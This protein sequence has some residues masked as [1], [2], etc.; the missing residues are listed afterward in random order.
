M[1]L[2]FRRFTVPVFI[3]LFT[4]VFRVGPARAQLTES[5][6]KVI[7][8]LDQNRVRSQIQYLSEGVVKT[9]SGQGAGTAVVGS[10]EEAELGQVVAAEMKKIGL[11]VRTEGY[12][13]RHYTSG[14]VTLT[15][16]GKPI[17]AI[18]LHAAGGTWG[19]RDGVPYAYG[20]EEHGHRLRA[21][22]V[23]AG[24]GYLPDY[25]RVGSVRGKIVLVRRGEIWP[26]YQIL[27][28]AHQG[29]VGLLMYDFPTAP[30][31]AIRQDS[32]W[33]HEQLPTASIAKDDAKR[34]QAQLKA[35]PVEI[36]LENRIDSADG[37]SQN[38]IGTIT[39][40]ELPDE[41]LLVAAHYD[42]WWQSANDNCAGAAT[43]LE[44]ARALKSSHPRRGI[45]FL[46][47]S[48]EE[49]GIEATEFDWLAGSHAFVT[50][51]PEIE[52]RLVY[53]FN[54]DMSGWTAK[55]AT[56]YT[57]PELAS[58]QPKVIADLDLASR[59]K[60]HLGQDPDQDAWNFGTVGGGSVS[61]L[62][63]GDFGG[64][65]GNDPD[66]NP[67]SQYYHT[68]L[69]VYRPQDFD[70]LQSH[71]RLGAL[72]LL[73]M[74]QAINAPVDFE[75]VADWI[76]K[77]WEGEQVLATG[78]SYSDAQE[79]LNQF[80]SEAARVGAARAKFASTAQATPANLWLMRVRK[81]LLPWVSSFSSTGVR[82]TPNAAVLAAVH[83]AR[84][85]AEKNDN[86]ST[87]TALEQVDAAMAGWETPSVKAAGVVSPEV[88][89]EERIYWYTSGDWSAA[90]EQK[91]RPLDEEIDNVYR[92]LHA[93]GR[94]SAE[95]AALRQLEAEAQAHLSEALFLVAG[96]LRDATAQVRET[97]LTNR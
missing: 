65:Q 67:F 56:L 17:Q 37:T 78:V 97:P 25:Q 74:D 18:S 95:A 77:A 96:K 46:A 12:P 1:T 62:V 73:R 22:L 7:D 71:L 16:S 81:N 9:K 63:W 54:I 80:R 31:A 57:T 86:L 8:A 34:L 39:G 2:A 51:H 36:V 45:L 55:R 44:L 90:Y 83:A 35:G 48:G 6:K 50:A 89:R 52:R 70:N 38:V 26:V 4:C 61:W 64:Y 30:D 68:Q 58:V 11:D 33:Y 13:V 32:M 94:A 66:P 91:P 3:F 88:S 87:I 41:W 47:S 93:G 5:E 24:D 85:A 75:A 14:P 19:L 60:L 82:T 59:V 53:G 69:D 28:A 23:D 29:A 43:M 84:V 92:R 42:R 20:N 49:A 79:A 76:Q 72:G 21:P 10:P 15:A 27:E 40:S